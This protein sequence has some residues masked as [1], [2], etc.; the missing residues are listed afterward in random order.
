MVKP[1][2]PA[3]GLDRCRYCRTL[4][5]RAA[6]RSVLLDPKM[7]SIFV[8]VSP[9]LVEQPP[10]VALVE[11]DDVVEQLSANRTHQALRHSIGASCRMHPMRAVRRNDF[12]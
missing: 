5:Y 3:S 8:V 6:Q 1:A 11:N 12:G 9:V 2:G 10:K 7:S 4:L